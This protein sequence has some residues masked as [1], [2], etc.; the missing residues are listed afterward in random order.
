MYLGV[1]SD[2]VEDLVVAGYQACVTCGEWYVGE[3]PKG[4]CQACLIEADAQ[5]DPGRLAY[6]FEG[7]TFHA[8]EAR[9]RRYPRSPDRTLTPEQTERKRLTTA[10]RTQACVR[11]IA[12]Y[13][14]MF[15]VLLAEEK[16]LRGVDPTVIRP[17][18][19][20]TATTRAILSARL[21]KGS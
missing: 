16:A 17:R 18:P 20:P 10:A 21:R 13:R 19:R 3:H 4:L 12:I 7:R 8:E 6:E 1:M 2:P 11:L 15:E 14:P 9:Q 5:P